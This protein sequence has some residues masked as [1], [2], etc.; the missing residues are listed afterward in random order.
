MVLVMCLTERQIAEHWHVHTVVLAVMVLVAESTN[1]TERVDHVVLEQT[2]EQTSH[3]D[4]K[5]RQPKQEAQTQE[6]S[7]EAKLQ[8]Q[9]V[10]VNPDV[11]LTPQQIDCEL[12]VDRRLV[13]MRVPTQKAVPHAMNRGM[14]VFGCVAVTV[15]IPTMNSDPGDT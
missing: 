8:R 9:I 6:Q 4:L 1:V 5:D 12:M 13:D 14:Q 10:L 7:I 11:V 2:D 3:V 15:V